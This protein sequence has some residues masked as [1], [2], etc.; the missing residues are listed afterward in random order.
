MDSIYNNNT[1]AD[2]NPAWHL[3]DSPWKAGLVS[4]MIDKHSL[5]MGRVAEVGCGAG[6]ILKIL[7]DKYPQSEF[8]GYEVSQQAFERCSTR[9]SPSLEFHL[10]DILKAD[11][12]FDIVLAIDVFEHV[13]DYL[14]FLSALRTK[15]KHKVF[16]IPLDLSVQTVFR[17]LRSG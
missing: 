14:G 3:K 1:Y 10:A 5:P 8:H 16:H 17:R 4:R 15:G 2:I 9:A 6:E 12:Y 11:E 13:E 7:S